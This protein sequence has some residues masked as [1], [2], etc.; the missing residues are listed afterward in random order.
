MAVFGVRL[1]MNEIWLVALLLLIHVTLVSTAVGDLGD[2]SPCTGVHLVE[3]PP[4]GIITPYRNAL[5]GLRG[6]E[7]SRRCYAK[8]PYA[9]TGPPILLLGKSPWR[10]EQPPAVNARMKPQIRV[11]RP[12]ACARLPSAALIDS[13]PKLC[14]GGTPHQPEQ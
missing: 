3:F 10:E 12:A 8:S 1:S 9:S 13:P 4:H 7:R 14:R 11:P 2:I 5:S 6:D